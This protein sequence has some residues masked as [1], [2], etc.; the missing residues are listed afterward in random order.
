MTLRVRL[1]K[2]EIEY[3]VQTLRERELTQYSSVLVKKLDGALSGK[4]KGG[5]PRLNS[6]QHVFQTETAPSSPVQNQIAGDTKQTSLKAQEQDV[7]GA[8][9]EKAVLA[10]AGIRE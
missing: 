4:N 3:L 5:R 7:F 2:N 1:E 10:L 9:L 6:E 8:F